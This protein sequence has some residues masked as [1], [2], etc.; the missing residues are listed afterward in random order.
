MGPAWAR[1][2][3]LW[4]VYPLGFVDAAATG[5]HYEPGSRIHRL[6]AYLDYV[7]ELG[8]NGVLLAPIF[9]SDSHG[10]DTRD[11]FSLDPRLGSDQDFAWF[12]DAA[13]QRGLR[14]IL[15]GVFNHVG[16]SFPPA[17][18]ALGDPKVAA[19][20][21][22]PE[23]VTQREAAPGVPPVEIP[24]FRVFEGHDSLVTLNHDSET[25]VNFIVQVMEHW[26]GL[27]VDGWRLDAAYAI[28]REPLR[29][30]VE[31]VRLRFPEALF[32]GEVI[33]GD[34]A[35]FVR[36]TGID[37]VTQYELWHAI[38]HSINDENFFELEWSLRRHNE[39]LQHFVPQTFIGNH[40]VTRIAT[41]LED[42]RH[43]EH[44]YTLLLTL[45][46]LPSIYYGDEQVFEGLKENRIGGDDAIRPAFPAEEAGAASALPRAGWATYRL[47]QRQISVRRNHP[48][49]YAAQSEVVHLANHAL[50][51]KI[52]GGGEF[53]YVCLNLS[54][55]VLDVTVPG[56][57]EILSGQGDL[58][59][60]GRAGARVIAP[61]HG[62]LVVAP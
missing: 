62:C 1:H 2:A 39:F 55:E 32:L 37:T 34:Y 16:R 51:L 58:V 26:L 57:R 7:V 33:H 18:A 27:G 44:A 12:V 38:H 41:T 29:R 54:D 9:A 21:F 14:I 15:D 52:V 5:H 22:I 24:Q 43:L 56:A 45:G 36:E 31:R 46:G 10:Y 50:V 3:I 13:K 6:S 17:Q 40:D 8:L 19:E 48:W 61:P 11:Y 47:H 4:H 20:W 28:P 35:D 25:V 59:D 53:L 30:A 49:L 42:P 23:G 60:S